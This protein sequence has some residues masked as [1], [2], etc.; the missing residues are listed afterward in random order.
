MGVIS[1]FRSIRSCR[2][3]V[4]WS[5]EPEMPIPTAIELPLPV[6]CLVVEEY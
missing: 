6:V 3:K 5:V 4:N 2:Y 1:I